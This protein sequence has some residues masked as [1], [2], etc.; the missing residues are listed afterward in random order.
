MIA[1]LVGKTDIKIV[2]NILEKEEEK[3]SELDRKINMRK[4]KQIRD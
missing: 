2:D 3:D 4:E 1:Q